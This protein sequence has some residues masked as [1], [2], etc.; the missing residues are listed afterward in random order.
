MTAI[1]SNYNKATIFIIQL[2]SYVKSDCEIK[3]SKTP[4]KEIIE[5]ID[6]FVMCFGPSFTH[7]YSGIKKQQ[8]KLVTTLTDFTVDRENRI[9]A[10]D[11]FNCAKVALLLYMNPMNYDSIEY[12]SETE[13]LAIDK[14]TP[15]NDIYYKY[16]ISGFNEGTWH[17]GNGVPM[18]I[19]ID[20]LMRLNKRDNH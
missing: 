12:V 6:N 3:I 7:N 17:P 11:S 4:S 2:R 19:T 15:K 18:K 8:I 13:I 10:F 9:L 14:F 5:T 1:I 20:D 16:S